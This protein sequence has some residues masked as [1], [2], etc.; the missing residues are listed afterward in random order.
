[1]AKAFKP[2]KV[3]EIEETILEMPEESDERLAS[4][5]GIGESTVRKHKKRLLDEGKMTKEQTKEGSRIR[6]IEKTILEMP[7]ESDERLASLLGIEE[8][9]VRKYKKRLIDEGKMTREQT[10]EES[11]IGKIEKTILKM[12]GKSSKIIAD[13]LGVGERT[14]RRYKKR[15]I[16]EG[17]LTKDENRPKKEIEEII[18][19]FPTESSKTLA[20]LLDIGETTVKVYR[21]RLIDE[22]RLTKEDID[23]SRREKE[24]IKNKYKEDGI[25]NL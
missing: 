13:L 8:C 20:T 11:R 1:M 17:R 3:K 5:L 12:P 22:R 2:E 25:R 24:Q 18:L 4:L 19:Q 10:K 16:E 9:T 15:L 21:R 14:V 23:K 6:K 7:G